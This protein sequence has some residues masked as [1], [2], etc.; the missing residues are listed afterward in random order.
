MS[1]LYIY[2]KLDASHAAAALMA[3]NAAR[4]DA[5]VRLL[6]RRDALGGPL[7]TWMEIYGV[8]VENPLTVEQRVALALTPFLQGSRHT[9]TF[10]A[11]G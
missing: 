7:L 2:Y 1:E 6:Q 3:F 4:T 5:P 11:I 9:E 10:E 8:D